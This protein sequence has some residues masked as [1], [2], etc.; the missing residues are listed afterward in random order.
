[1]ARKI[2]RYDQ[3]TIRSWRAAPYSFAI[4]N[5]GYKR[6]WSLYRDFKVFR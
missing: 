6:A 4:T 1:M 2:V 5:W 3:Y